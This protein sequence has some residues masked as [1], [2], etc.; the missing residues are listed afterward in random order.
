MDD[1][2]EIFQQFQEQVNRRGDMLKLK[3]KTIY[4]R[5]LQMNDAAEMFAA[6]EESR[7]ELNE[8]F[9]WSPLVRAVK[10][11][12][13]FI[14]SRRKITVKGRELLLGIFTSDSERYLGNVGLH[15]VPASPH[16]AEVGYWV[17]TSA[18]GRGVAT[19]AAA[20]VTVAAFEEFRYHRLVLRAA[21]DNV[22]SNRVAEKLGM[23]LGGVQRHELQV[24]RGYLDLNYYTLLDREYRELADSIK[25]RLI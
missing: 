15:P 18:V 9:V 4:L 2:S 10:D 6:I 25:A 19:A 20:L 5:K 23:K 3:G 13:E 22:A 12:E 21:T 7:N 24:L 8:F 16:S 17:R 1:D 14:K 11:S